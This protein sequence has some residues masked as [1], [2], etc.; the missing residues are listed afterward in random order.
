MKEKIMKRIYGFFLL[1]PLA[2][3]SSLS[4][5]LQAHRLWRWNYQEAPSR[6]DDAL[7]SI[8]DP[9]IPPVSETDEAKII[10]RDE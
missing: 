3:C 5:E 9:L 2:G 4:H 1:L 6:T 10:D 7:F 8:D